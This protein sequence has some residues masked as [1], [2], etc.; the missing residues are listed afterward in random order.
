MHV[1]FR[2]G[3][4][5]A[6]YSR[7]RLWTCYLVLTLGQAPLLAAGNTPGPDLT[8]MSMESLMNLE[9]TSA[10]RKSQR[11]SNTAA[12][13]YVITKEEIRRSGLTRVPELL[14]L[15]PGMQVSRIDASRWA[16]TARGFA[17]EFSNK[18]LVLVDGRSAYTEIFSGVYWDSQDTLVD[19]IE[20]I[21]VVRGP[22]AAMWGANAV[23]GVINIITKN[24]RDTQGS[25]ISFG[26]GNEDGPM[27]LYRFGGRAGG[28]TWYR[29]SAGYSGGVTPAA[30]QPKDAAYRPFQAGFRMDS[31]LS[32]RDKLMLRLSVHNS[33]NRS[34]REV[35]QSSPPW[36]AQRAN[37]TDHQEGAILARW[38]RRL[39]SGEVSIQGYFEHYQLQDLWRNESQSTADLE[40]QHRMRLNSRHELN[41]GLGIRQIDDRLDKGLLS[42]TPGS[43]GRRKYSFFAQDEWAL[44]PEA[45]TLTAGSKFEHNYFTGFEI[46]PTLR[47]MWTPDPVQS[48]WA[49]VSR[50]VRTPSRVDRGLNLPVAAMETPYGPPGMVMISPNPGFRSEGLLAYE[51][52]YR[53]QTSQRLS[54]DLTAFYNRYSHLS[55]FELSAPYLSM[56]SESPHLVLPLIRMNGGGGEV[57]G[58]ELAAQA[59]LTDRWKLFGSYS[60]LE[61]RLRQA[62]VFLPSFSTDFASSNSPSYQAQ[63]R[64]QF[65]LSSRW[66]LD[67]S[68]YSVGAITALRIPRYTRADVRMACQLSPDF[69][70]SLNGQNLL[71]PEH[72][73]FLSEGME[74]AYPIRRSVFLRI[75]GRF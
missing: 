18:L 10:S 59:T 3:R 1:N 53:N 72:V 40:L 23:N 19:D 66:S 47:L 51:L 73:E 17:G 33:W 2:Q 27:T 14:R 58:A 61:T 9:V 67:A 7:L 60:R 63:G 38:S 5:R 31:D 28:A 65:N 57:H 24:A 54:I 50:A 4:S 56:E 55:A 45:I 39:G 42:I 26:A 36:M 49:A 6:R 8:A 16:I 68:V 62:S 75:T 29:F 43:M 11:L 70:L 48:V 21:E 44:W 34:Y 35:P 15:V 71:R 22:G 32:D 37:E 46:Q 52:G 13:V 25:L 12:A 41:W 64:S 69:E 74:R 30:G 20:R